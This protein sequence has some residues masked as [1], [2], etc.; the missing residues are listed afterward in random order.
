MLPPIPVQKKYLLLLNR[1][2]RKLLKIE[3]IP[4]P[5]TLGDEDVQ[6]Y[7]EIHLMAKDNY[8]IP[9][10]NKVLQ[11]D[12][13][14]FAKLA[15]KA[16]KVKAP[17]ADKPAKPAKAPKAEKPTKAP[18]ADKPAKMKKVKD[19]PTSIIPAPPAAGSAEE[20][21]LAAKR[22]EIDMTKRDANE[23]AKKYMITELKD[24]R[25][26]QNLDALNDAKAQYEY[27]RTKLMGLGVTLPPVD[28]LKKAKAPRKKA[29][30]KPKAEAGMM[31]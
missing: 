28:S 5:T 3:L 16:P 2:Y 8:F 1:Q 27:N 25:K 12:E 11:A 10:T 23:A 14:E 26:K 17:K 6:K 24:L 15:P 20:A 18:K 30:P 21:T 22:A 7:F 29:A 31:M 19:M 9:K 4:A 13:K